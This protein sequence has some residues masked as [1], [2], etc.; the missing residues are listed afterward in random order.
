VKALR[1]NNASEWTG[2]TG[3]NTY[4]LPGPPSILIDAG[5]GDGTHLESIA[6]ALGGAPLDL[7]LITHG[8]VDHAAGAPAL[9]RRWPD[10][11]IRGGGAGK[12]LDDG[13]VF[14]GGGTT[15]LAIHTP[16]HAAD[17]FCLL[18]ESTRDIYCG[19]LVRI[20]GTVVIPASRGG[21]LRDYLASLARIRALEPVRLLPAHGPLVQDPR[22][23]IDEYLAHRAARERQI[24]EALKDGCTRVDDLV[25]RIYPDLS[26]SLRHAAEETVRAHLAK[27]WEDGLGAGPEGRACE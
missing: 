25:A 14:S 11:A 3:N 5:V 13:E 6:E 19:D 23:L 21:S 9:A 10:V 24:A 22:A 1:A 18:D 16:G 17:H 2:P 15:L 4:V 7:V 20:G 12:P 27:L 26:P 8:H